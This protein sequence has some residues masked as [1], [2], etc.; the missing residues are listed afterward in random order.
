MKKAL[1]LG[2]TSLIVQRTLELMAR[3]GYEFYLVA[4][5]EDKLKSVKAHLETISNT[6]IHIDATNP[7]LM[8]SQKDIFARA[9]QTLKSVDYLLIGY[10]TLP[11]QK[12]LEE[13]PENIAEVYN[14]N[15]V[16]ISHFLLLVVDYFMKRGSGVIAVISSVAGERGRQSNFVYG[17]TKGGLSVFLEGYRQKMSKHNVKVITIKPGLVETPMTWGIK[18]GFLMAKPEKVARDIY[19]GI[20]KEKSVVYTPWYWKYVMLIIR[21]IPERVFQKLEL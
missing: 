3:D 17:S 9:L 15:L 5:N 16:S 2:A 14:T 19:T 21:S 11:N 10:G 13:N 20:A 18:R 6:K 8:E 7:S 4:R 1:V 12:E